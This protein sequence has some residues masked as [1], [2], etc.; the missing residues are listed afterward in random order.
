MIRFFLRHSMVVAALTTSFL[1]SALLAGCGGSTIESVIKPAQIIAFGDGISDVGNSAGNGRYTVNDGNG[2]WVQRVASSYGVTLTS[3]RAGGRGYAQGNARVLAKPD[4]TGSATTLSV[5]EQIDSY[6][7]SN[8][9]VADANAIILVGAGYA[10]VIAEMASFTAGTN[11]REQLL[12][13]VRQ[14]GRD[15][16]AQVRRLTAAGARYIV[17]AGT[18]DLG[19]SPWATAI[20]QRALLADASR[21]FN[22]QF[23]ISV[24][25]LGANVLYIDLALQFN[26]IFAAPSSYGIG[27]TANPVCTSVDT[28]PGIGIGSGQVNS[29]LCNPTTTVNQKDYALHLFA[30]RV[31]P[32]PSGHQL[33]ADYA[34]TRIKSRW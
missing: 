13:N 12:I 18:Y 2:I 22:D 26:L 4:A 33:F 32:T 10:D 23:L 20:N 29:A 30:D 15:L 5:K 16:G 9:G 11:N 14:A 21:A 31:Y 34:V 28:G 6:L 3:A 17:V 1:A 27:D 8:G 25:D 24:V 7:G 19:K